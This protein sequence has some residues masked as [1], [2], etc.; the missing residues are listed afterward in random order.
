MQGVQFGKICAGLVEREG[1]QFQ[2]VIAEDES[3]ASYARFSAN[4]AKQRWSLEAWFRCARLPRHCTYAG[5]RFVEAW[6]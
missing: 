3:G 6:L 1:E 5:T 4:D 2:G